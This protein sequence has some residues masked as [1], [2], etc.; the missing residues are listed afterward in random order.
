MGD[1][2][3]AI[4]KIWKLLA[5]SKSANEHE[6][7]AAALAVARLL[8][9]HRLTEGDIAQTEVVERQAIIDADPWVQQLA[10]TIAAGCGCRILL[11]QRTAGVTVVFVGSILD[12]DAA[13]RMLS[14]IEVQIRRL[15][16][17][18]WK[19]HVADLTDPH[20]GVYPSLLE[21]GAEESWKLSFALG[22]VEV[23][24]LKLF[25]LDTEVKTGSEVEALMRMSTSRDEALGR[26]DTYVKGK[27]PDARPSK[28]RQ[29]YHLHM[30]A[31]TA[32]K[33]TDVD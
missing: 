7:A 6:A 30:G 1:R 21:P 31:L 8:A 18:G 23:V 19:A 13:L 25:G 3:S 28:A 16:D 10:A 32:G 24:R 5:L 14:R 2:A 15:M 20:Y 22:A 26:V 33:Q 27:W 12:A 29:T 11:G 9:E 4:T 17:A